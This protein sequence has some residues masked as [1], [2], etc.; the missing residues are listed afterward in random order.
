VRKELYFKAQR[1]IIDRVYWL[2]FFTQ[3]DIHGS[4]KKL[5]YEL[6]P[7]QVPRYQYATWQ[8]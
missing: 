2:P 1:M 4:N 7:D 6:G 5:S 3:R 8:E